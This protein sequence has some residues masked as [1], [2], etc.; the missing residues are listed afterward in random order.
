[1]VTGR[2]FEDGLRTEIGLCFSDLMQ[3]GQNMQY[4][5][6]A[7]KILGNLVHAKTNARCPKTGFYAASLIR[8]KFFACL[9]TLGNFNLCKHLNM[10]NKH[11]K[12]IRK[13]SKIQFSDISCLSQ[14]ESNFLNFD[15]LHV[16]HAP[17]FD[18]VQSYRIKTHQFWCASHFWSAFL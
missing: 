15:N 16:Q 9:R 7:I 3:L 1:M 13:Q 2:H 11:T 10:H 14:R 18:Q 17:Y 4:V 6:Q 12:T 8:T 5:V